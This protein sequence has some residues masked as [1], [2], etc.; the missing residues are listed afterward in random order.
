MSVRTKLEELVI[1]ISQLTAT[2][3]PTPPLLSREVWQGVREDLERASRKFA[4]VR[5]ALLT[6]RETILGEFAGD[7]EREAESL[8]LR[9]H[10]ISRR[11]PPTPKAELAEDNTHVADANAD[12]TKTKAREANAERANSTVLPPA[13][14]AAENADGE[15]HRY[16]TI[17]HQAASTPSTL[18]RSAADTV[19]TARVKLDAAEHPDSAAQAFEDE[20]DVLAEM[21]LSLRQRWAI[22]EAARLEAAKGKGGKR[23]AANDK[24]DKVRA[25]QRGAAHNPAAV[26]AAD[27]GGNV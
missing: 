26:N 25:A 13:P 16:E 21:T 10:M 12:I 4:E 17:Q 23:K 22:A 14:A 24:A 8:A 20:L 2:A 19:E 9:A 3:E 1:W 27:D 11:T 15:Q 7:L 5:A 18:L 6:A